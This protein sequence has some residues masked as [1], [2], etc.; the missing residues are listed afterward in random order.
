M[1]I[2]IYFVNYFTAN[3]R[4]FL[5]VFICLCPFVCCTLKF[6][7]TNVVICLALALYLERNS[8]LSSPSPFTRRTQ[9]HKYKEM[10]TTGHWEITATQLSQFVRP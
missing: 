5:G 8:L 6:A 10:W 2:G 3:S 7:A 1:F 9:R 4:L